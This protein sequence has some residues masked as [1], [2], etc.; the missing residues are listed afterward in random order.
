MHCN[1]GMVNI[2]NERDKVP[3]ENIMSVKQ[4]VEWTVERVKKDAP[5]CQMISDLLQ[6]L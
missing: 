4:W 1:I 2:R 3:A 5:V 6:L